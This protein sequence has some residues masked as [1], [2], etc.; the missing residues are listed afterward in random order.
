[1]PRSFTVRDAEGRAA[2]GF[3]VFRVLKIKG[4]LFSAFGVLAGA[5]STGFLN[6]TLEPHLR[7]VK[8][9]FICFIQKVIVATSQ[10]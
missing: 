1:M 10:H 3:V 7:Q 4:V 9:H 8:K 2:E 6:S 5:C